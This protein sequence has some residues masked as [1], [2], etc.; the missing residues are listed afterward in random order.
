MD[1]KQKIHKHSIIQIV[2]FIVLI[3][4]DQLSKYWVVQTLKGKPDV[5]IIKD[6]IVFRYLENNGA[7]FGFMENKQILFYI[8]TVV[9]LAIVVYVTITINKRL[10][11]Y[12]KLDDSLFKIKTFHNG[13]ILNYALVILG[14]GAIGNF[15]D[16]V[17]HSYVVD[18]IYFKFINFPIF[19]FADICVT[20]SAIFLVIFF[21]FVYKEDT[22]FNI[23]SSKKGK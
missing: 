21:L 23:F 12:I 13:I 4:I 8:I 14:A 16:R 11:S 7:A 5:P 1:Y 17:A 22:N 9:V 15:I 6:A 10:N 20:C 18:F 2:L 19:N 3:A